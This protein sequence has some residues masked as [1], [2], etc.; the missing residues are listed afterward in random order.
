M[1]FGMLLFTELIGNVLLWCFSFIITL[2]MY[3]F[4]IGLGNFSSFGPGNTFSTCYYTGTLCVCVPTPF[5][6]SLLVMNL[7]QNIDP[8]VYTLYLHN[9]KLIF[10]IISLGG[11][12]VCPKANK[13]FFRPVQWLPYPFFFEFSGL[14]L[15]F[16]LGAILCAT[17]F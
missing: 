6:F 12:N 7:V 1:G 17:Q 16:F 9:K 15:S 11:L 2:F 5:F 10:I 13:R 3:F 4:G 14:A 8:V